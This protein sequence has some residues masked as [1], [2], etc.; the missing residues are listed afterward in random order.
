MTATWN[1]NLATGSAFGSGHCTNLHR[2]GPWGQL[3]Y[4]VM[5]MADQSGRY[6]RWIAKAPNDRHPNLADNQVGD[7]FL[8]ISPDKRFPQGT[9]LA[10]QTGRANAGAYW[11]ITNQSGS[12]GFGAQWVRPDR[13]TFR[14]SYYRWWAHD[15]WLTARGNFPEIPLEEMQLLK[16]EGLYRQNNRAG[17]ATLINLSRTKYG[18]NATDA[19]GTN[20]SCVPKLPNGNCGDLFEMLKWEKRLETFFKGQHHS[21][22]YF[23]GRGWG[24]LAEGVF[25]QLPIPG[26]E[27]QLLG[28]QT[29]TFGGTGGVS[30]APKGT[31]GY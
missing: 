8:I 18:L 24:D 9:T 5:G 22:W 20:T 17:A 2:F 26:G 31:Y 1:I 13:G 7:P 25:L 23:D 14:W 30:A 12:G 3:S 11:E 29:Y 16:A 15:A 21:S 19:A 27:A 10:T 6:Q 4:Q 28:V